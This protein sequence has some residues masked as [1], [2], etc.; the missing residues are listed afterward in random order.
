MQNLKYY[1]IA[2]VLTL[3]LV[4]VVPVLAQ[5]QN[6]Q[7]ASGVLPKIPVL[8]EVEEV[9]IDAVRELFAEVGKQWQVA[10]TK[11]K[12][13]TSLKKYLTSL[14]DYAR[15]SCEEIEIDCGAEIK[16]LKLLAKGATKKKLISEVPKLLQTIDEK[17]AEALLDAEDLDLDLDAEDME[18]LQEE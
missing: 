6:P 7:K 5:M 9:D 12:K 8:S 16:M 13:T 2:A 17:F 11:T 4:V 3:T 15:V 14:A 1:I 10:V 18:M